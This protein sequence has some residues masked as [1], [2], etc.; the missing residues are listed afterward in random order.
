MFVPANDFTLL[1][2][3]PTM[4]RHCHQFE[5][6]DLTVIDFLT[7]HWINVDEIFDKH[8][9]D[10]QKPHIPF[11]FHHQIQAVAYWSPR[12]EI[13]FSQKNIFYKKDNYFYQF[14]YIYSPCFSF[15][16]PPS[17]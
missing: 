7:D 11:H 16:H 17:T 4:Y 10:E 13:A 3:I 5:D 8:E 1:G 2:E 15:F 12:I 9:H 6:K 14:P